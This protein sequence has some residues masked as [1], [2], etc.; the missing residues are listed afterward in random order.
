MLVRRPAVGPDWRQQTHRRWFSILICLFWPV[1]GLTY[2]PLQL[3]ITLTP[4]G[5]VLKLEPGT[6][7]GPAVVDRPIT[8]DGAGQATVDGSGDGTVITVEADGVTLRGLHIVNSGNSHDRLDAGIALL[9][10]KA[11]IEDNII[12]DVLFGIQLQEAHDNQVRR[13]RISSRDVEP[14]LRGE[15]LRLWY[16]SENLFEGNTI[17]R[18]RDLF[19][20]NSPDNRFLG[21]QIRHSRIA[22]E[23][24]FS[25]GSQVEDCL[26]EENDRGIV[27]VYSDDILLRGNRFRHL[28][29]FAGSALSL[30]ES[31]QI[32]I[33]DNQVLHCAVGMT[34]NAPIHP[35][36]T[37]HMIGNRF[38]YNDIALYFY[39]EKGG[40]AIIDNRF[41][42]NLRQVAVS[43]P[44]SARQ[45]EW[46]NNHWDDYQGFDLD[47]DGFGDTPHDLYLHSDRIWMD[48]PMTSFFRGSPVMQV[49]DF[50]ERLLPFSEPQLV[51]RDTAPRTR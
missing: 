9:A 25:P 8:I 20:T 19:I 21:N 49:I 45:H 6:Y 51:L 30:K 3:Y 12:E 7:S 27:V 26:I 38:A 43:H 39:G 13:N 24:V 5:G 16:S 2:P 31:S 18:V 15:R 32:L 42:H 46:R 1:V 37:F 14:S 47:G 4:P 17:E 10:N 28:R 41:E 44:V 35:E 11:H 23:F 48:R 33:E 36:N 22:M 29:S 34:A 40:H 50:A